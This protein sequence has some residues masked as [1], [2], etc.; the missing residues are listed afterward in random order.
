ML[1]LGKKIVVAIDGSPASDKAAEEAVRLASVSGSRFVSTVYAVLVLPEAQTSAV[2][3]YLPAQSSG[4]PLSMDETRRRIFSVVEKVA[5][6]VGAPLEK[7]TRYGE[8]VDEILAVTQ[9]Q[10]ADVIVVGSSGKGRLQRALHGSVST[11]LSLQAR[12]SV[13]IVR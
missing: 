1:N 11:K 5:R 2:I 4:Q 3:D 9:E 13:Y 10:A 12:C 8:P 7:F 6:E